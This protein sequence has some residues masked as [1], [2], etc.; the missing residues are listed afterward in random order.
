MICY[1]DATERPVKNKLANSSCVNGERW[2]SKKIKVKKQL[3]VERRSFERGPKQIEDFCELK[4]HNKIKKLKT[5]LFRNLKASSEGSKLRLSNF[6][7]I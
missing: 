6:M 5:Q 1:G 2:K 4:L 7:P 3:T